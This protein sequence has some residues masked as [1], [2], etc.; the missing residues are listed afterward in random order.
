M[1]SGHSEVFKTPLVFEILPQINRIIQISQVY[2]RFCHNP[3]VKFL[4]LVKKIDKLSFLSYF[5]S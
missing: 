4:N 5:I 1:D 2:Y 3:V